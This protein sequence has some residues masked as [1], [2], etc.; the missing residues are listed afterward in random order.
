M[1]YTTLIYKST[2]CYSSL[3]QSQKQR[4]FKK[5]EENAR[6]WSRKQREEGDQHLWSCGNSLVYLPN[7]SSLDWSSSLSLSFSLF[8][9]FHAI[10][11]KDCT[12]EENVS[13]YNSLSVL[14]LT[15]RRVSVFA[16]LL[17]LP[18]S[19]WEKMDLLCLMELIMAL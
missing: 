10:I 3:N 17:W 5:K 2:C 8:S 9:Y 13:F 12:K 7:S 16:S 15:R 14:R 11:V 6:T 1:I 18:L 19:S 4:L